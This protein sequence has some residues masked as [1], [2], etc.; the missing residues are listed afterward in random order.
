MLLP[1]RVRFRG[2]CHMEIK[3]YRKALEDFSEAIK[4]NPEDVTSR[5]LIKECINEFTRK[6]PI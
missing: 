6:L 1:V 2:F 3:E 5:D 4:I